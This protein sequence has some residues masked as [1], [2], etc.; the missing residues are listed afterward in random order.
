ML[1][2]LKLNVDAGQANA[3]TY[4][5]VYDRTQ[6]DQGKKQ[7]DGEQLECLPGHTLIEAPI[8]DEA[9]VNMRRAEFGL[10]RVD[11]YARLVKLLSPDMCGSDSH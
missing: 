7:L 8:Q 1:P 2:K 10:F 11:L 9:T 4:A 5:L 6:R 3:G